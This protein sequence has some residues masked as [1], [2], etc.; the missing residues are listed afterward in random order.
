MIIIIIL[1]IL[2]I[3]YKLDIINSNWNWNKVYVKSNIDN[4]EYLVLNKDDKDIAANQLA[5]LRKKLKQFVKDLKNKYPSD[6][7]IL[8]LNV[9]F[10]PD[11]FSEGS[12][13]G[14]YTSYSINKG[15]KIIFCIR[16]RNEK[17]DI[18]DIN[19]ITFVAL[20]ELS[21]VM[22]LSIGH[23]K[24]FWDNFRFLL[25]EAINMNIY[26]YQAF[27]LYPQKYCGITITN[28][29]YKVNKI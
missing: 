5:L 27:H 22:T 7:K 21:H 26:K 2:L 28:T 16:Q 1:L 11:N 10:R 20:H 8:R 29:P 14:S 3:L 12:A 4:R 9:R 19:T 13:D 18:I 25:K 23:E 6:E 17:N 24:E 15:E